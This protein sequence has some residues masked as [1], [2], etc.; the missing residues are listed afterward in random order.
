MFRALS[1]AEIDGRE[2]A[3]SQLRRHPDLRCA[4]CAGEYC[5]GVNLRP[6][7]VA[8]GIVVV[9]SAAS[10]SEDVNLDEPVVAAEC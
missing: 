6:V 5:D 8:A 2:M 10:L 4:K 3:G 9:G 7:P 1:A